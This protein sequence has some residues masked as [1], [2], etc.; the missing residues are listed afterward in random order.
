MVVKAALEELGIKYTQVVLGEA[1][2]LESITEE[3]HKQLKRLLQ[4]SGLEL[5]DDETSMLIE[6]IKNVVIEMVHYSDNVPKEKFSVYLS[7]K[8]H[9]NYA[10]MSALFSE[11]K[12]ITIEHYIVANKIER[13]KE[14][15]LYDELNLTEISYILNYSSVA[16]L[17][18]QFKKLTGL[19]PS[20][21]KK[22]KQYRTRVALEDI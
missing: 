2:L 3:E 14:L 20:Y 10:H 22:L 16:H 15:L 5:I 12:G 6:K 8:L 7:E 17:S 19:T 21:F 4:Q 9:E 1:D 11:I 18:N 13:I